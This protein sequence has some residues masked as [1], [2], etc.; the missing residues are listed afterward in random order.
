MKSIIY[1]DLYSTLQAA[2]LIVFISNSSPQLNVKER[3][4]GHWEEM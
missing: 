1:K 2:F 4:V 3:F